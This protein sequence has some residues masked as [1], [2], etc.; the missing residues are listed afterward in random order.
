MQCR[1]QVVENS[2]AATAHVIGTKPRWEIDI[3]GN[4]EWMMAS[5]MAVTSPHQPQQSSITCW[6]APMLL[7]SEAG[8]CVGVAVDHES[9]RAHWFPLCF[10]SLLWKFIH[11]TAVEEEAIE[12]C[13]TLSFRLSMLCCRCPEAFTGHILTQMMG[14][15]CSNWWYWYLS[16]CSLGFYWA[17]IGCN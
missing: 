2:R 1:P 11:I 7:E 3:M 8:V 17:F 14:Q 12:W 15:K 4:G 10:F 9:L 6:R 13:D 16:N 5:E